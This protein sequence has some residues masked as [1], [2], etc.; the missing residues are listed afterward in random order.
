[1]TRQAKSGFIAIITLLLCHPQLHAQETRI[2]TFDIDVTPPV[3]FPMAYDPVRRID[4]LGL[5]ARGIVILTAQKPIVLCAIDWI[6]IGNEAHDQFRETIATAAGTSADR[7]TVNT[8]H[9]HDAPRC[10]FSAERILNDAGH[11]SHGALQGGFAR[12][13]LQKL[14][15]AVEEAVADAK[16]VTHCAIGEATVEKVASNRRLQD[17]EGKVVKTRYTTCTDPA[18]RALP[19]GIIDPVVTSITFLNGKQPVAVLTY[20]ACHPQSYYRT[21]IP[22]PD[23]PGI[24]RFLRGQDVPDCLHVHFNGAGGNIGAG[25]YND[26]NKRNRVILAQR[27]AEGMRTAF[28]AAQPVELTADSIKWAVAPVQLPLGKHLNVTDLKQ[29]VAD[30]NSKDYWNA[31]EQLAFAERCEAGHQTELS[32]LKIGN[33]RILHMPGELFVEYQLAAKKL[34]PKL[35]VAMAAYAD[36]GPGY[37]G[38][39]DAYG[40]GGYETSPTA[41]K[42]APEVERVLM[43]GIKKLL[44]ATDDPPTQATAS[45][46]SDFK[47]ELPRIL[48]TPPEKALSTFQVADGYE[49]QLMASEPLIGTP[50]AIEWDATGRLFVCEMRGYSED[51]DDAISTIGRLEDTDND[52]VFD[53]RT[54]FATGLFWPTAI[55]PYDGGLFVADAP[56]LL[57]LKDTN[58][59]DKADIREVVLTGFGTS[60]VQGLLNSMRWGLDNRIH[61]ACS[62]VGGKIRS[63]NSRDPPVDIRG[64]D[65]AFDPV[66]YEFEITTATAQHGMCFD[67]WGRKFSSANSDHIIQVMYEDR[68][69]SRNPF[70]KAPS[71]KASIAADGPQAEVFRT[72][73]VEPWRV[74]RTRLRVQ[75]QAKGPI[76]GGG[77]AAGYFTGATGITIYRGDAWAEADHGIAIVGDVGSNLV[78]RKRLSGNALPF[79]ANRIDQ[80]SEFITSTD[81]WFRPS[82]FANGPDGC[83][84]VVDTYR[85][86][87]EHPKSLPPEIKQHLDLTAGRNRGRIYRVFPQNHSPRSM[88]NLK[89]ATTSELVELLNHA[90]AWHRET[91]ARLL[92][93][94]KDE[95]AVPLLEQLVRQSESP[96]GRL[97]ALSVL[98]GFESLTAQ[99]LLPVLHDDHPQVRRH[100][101]RFATSNHLWPQPD[102]VKAAQKLAVDSA[103]EV[104]IQL[105]WGMYQVP[106]TDRANILTTIAL[107]P[108]HSKWT[109][110]AIQSSVGDCGVDIFEKL[111]RQPSSNEMASGDLM[112]SLADQMKRQDHPEQQLRALTALADVPGHQA[113]FYIPI[114][115]ALMP[116]NQKVSINDPQILQDAQQR[117]SLLLQE[118]VQLATDNTRSVSDRIQAIRNLSF[119]DWATIATPLRQLV[120]TREVFD[121]RQATLQVLSQFQHPEVSDILLKQFDTFSP[122]LQRRSLQILVSRN[123]FHTP[124]IQAIQHELLSNKDL[125]V[126]QWRQLTKSKQPDVAGFA[127]KVVQTFSNSSRT[128]VIQNYQSALTLNASISQ[129]KEVFR[130]Q[131]SICHKADGIGKEIGP[132]LAAMKAKGPNSIL[133]NV[134]DPNQ[135]VNPQYLN[136]NVITSGGL[137]ISGMIESE[138]S[139]S[140]IL[141]KSDGTS[142]TI[143]RSEIEELT[144]THKSLMP[145]GLERTISQQNMADLIA[146]LM[147]PG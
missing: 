24:A 90:N 123:Q 79:T 87:I 102:F 78:H 108:Q 43:D 54:D 60:N 96:L 135:E 25:K 119:A 132:N 109:D 37:I 4:E 103:E 53:K 46:Q 15:A 106:S 126:A 59:D 92:V 138:G 33:A 14:K 137:T 139:S 7:V 142:T 73:P 68:D 145:E 115:A 101:V 10:D 130:T 110:V 97:H 144:N 6:G 42:V 88:P 72:S 58:N 116:A 94:R 5:R 147:Q 16:S 20:Y 44:E 52:S 51:R 91:S 66:T 122:A 61:I 17:E 27:L 80:E 124:L 39:A 19:E 55:F 84:Y 36:Y 112:H 22:S 114:Y 93:E 26:G 62:S 133:V 49:M 63:P 41:S 131:C 8:L 104:R 64:R 86:V 113:R 3:G 121:V 70:L 56:D 11:V 32:C 34:R 77:R 71:A 75:G 127:G 117:F 134:L 21:G 48:P 35:N 143:L 74:V 38:T 95:A 65:I 136:F 31:P 107:A 85:E 99:T 81:N 47:A 9:Q 12:S 140:I 29:K 100:A 69:I 120:D 1:M 40:Q 98:E 111:C 82:Q 83:L 28:E 50:V 23:F 30:W 18:L 118:S 129:G 57:Y 67:D 141:R 13:C 105:A 128:D 45:P 125:T 76:E 146:F 2:A 89:A